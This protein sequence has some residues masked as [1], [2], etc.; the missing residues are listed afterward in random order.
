MFTRDYLIQRRAHCFQQMLLSLDQ[1]EQAE[2]Q[3]NWRTDVARKRH[4]LKANE[5]LSVEAVLDRSRD[6]KWQNA[7]AD[8]RYTRERAAM[9]ATVYR[10]LTDR[11]RT[12]GVIG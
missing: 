8:C 10:E 9:Y 4:N 1:F 6:E 7:V 12:A 3:F 11:L 5:P 2:L